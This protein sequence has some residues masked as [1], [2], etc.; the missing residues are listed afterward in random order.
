MSRHIAETIIFSGKLVARAPLHVG[1]AEPGG[2]TD[3]ILAVDGA[4]RYYL[5]GTTLAGVLRQWF[6]RAFGSQVATRMFGEA[7][8]RSPEGHASFVL[9]EDA[10]LISDHMPEVRDGVGIDR[11]TGTAAPNIKYTRQIL[12]VGSEFDFI[13]SVDLQEPDKVQ[14]Q[15][16][17]SC[18]I[19]ALA[20]G[21][22]ALGAGKS[23]GLGRIRLED[24][25]VEHRNMSSRE[26]LLVWLEKGGKKTPFDP[27]RYAHPEVEPA[28]PQ[29][30]S[31]Q[32]QW[33]Q[34]GPLMVKADMEALE[35]DILPLYTGWGKRQR[36][37]PGASIK[38]ALRSM[39]ERILTTLLTHEGLSDPASVREGF[40]KQ[41]D[42][43]SLIQWLFGCRG[44]KSMANEEKRR[45]GLGA[46]RID[47]CHNSATITSDEWRK[48]LEAEKAEDTEI[49]GMRNA[50]HVAIDRWT[51]GAA[52]HF[53]YSVL[54]PHDSAWEEIHIQV[55][56]TRL[57]L[58]DT[59]RNAA[60]A[61]LI[62]VLREMAWGNIP[63][64][65]GVNRG[66]G[67]VVIERI[68]ISDPDGLLDQGKGGEYEL[69]PSDFDQSD[70]LNFLCSIDGSWREWLQRQ[71]NREPEEVI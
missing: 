41:T 69:C 62:L 5:P 1:G 12:P 47:D 39:A 55:D 20:K 16:R 24:I 25:H 32:I 14:D 19:E 70:K 37:I 22:V 59:E 53:L 43:F 15:A 67:V 51:G 34:D 49:D 58:D 45:P 18:L 46:L 3:L 10:P 33:L 26:A 64:G 11:F 8:D 65:F 29:S 38:G 61:L 44:R 21:E 54:E 2:E 28:S 40:L 42:R 6:E 60:L 27:A 68:R 48:L 50:M 35:V 30:L 36:V 23:R 63:L 52:E 71:G 66:M 56:A 31:I 57:P 7:R 17:M 4:G 9:I 13:L